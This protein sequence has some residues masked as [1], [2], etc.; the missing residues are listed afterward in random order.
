MDNNFYAFLLTTLAGLSTLI[1]SFIIF[2]SKKKQD[3]TIIGSLGFASGVMII[4]SLTDLI[5]NGFQLFSRTYSTIFS[6]L[7]LLIAMNIGVLLSKSINKFIPNNNN[8]LYRVG[9]LSMLAIMLHNIPEGI[10]TYITNCSNIN[11]GLSLTLAIAAH[12]IPEG[13]SISVPIYYATGNKRKAFLYTFISGISELFGAI[14][15]ALFLSPFV[16][17]TLMAFLYA[18][19]AGIMIY[20][21]ITEL[22]KTSLSYQKYK[23]TL[24]FFII[25]V[26]FILINHFIFN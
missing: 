5:P 16:S 8:F 4:V 22:L 7:L 12:N 11:L 6:I 1:G 19:I 21:S 13:I 10:A 26:L 3:S 25:G 23:I 24:I 14:I 9:I 15:S 18:M 20:L 17:D 2:F